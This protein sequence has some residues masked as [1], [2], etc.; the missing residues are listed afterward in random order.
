MIKNGIRKLN[1]LL[2]QAS[3][4]KIELAAIKHYSVKQYFFSPT[5]HYQTLK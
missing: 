3:P 4:A 5:L 2:H 1:T